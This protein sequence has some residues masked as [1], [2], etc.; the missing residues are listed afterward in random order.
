MVSPSYTIPI[1]KGALTLSTMSGLFA[2]TASDLIYYYELDADLKIGKF[3][4]NYHHL[5]D[6]SYNQTTY[7]LEYRTNW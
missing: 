3:A 6:G 7:R 4:A 5:N 2:R 1:A